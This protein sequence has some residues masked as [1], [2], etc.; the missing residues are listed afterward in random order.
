MPRRERLPTIRLHDL[1]GWP[2]PADR[3]TP[4]ADPSNAKWNG[5]HLVLE[6]ARFHWPKGSAPGADGPLYGRLPGEGGADPRYR[7]VSALLALD[8]MEWEVSATGRLRL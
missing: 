8:R 5:H 2:L 4:I 3:E 1:H 6:V 7:Q